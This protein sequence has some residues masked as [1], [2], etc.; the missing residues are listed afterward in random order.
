MK[1]TLLALA[2]VAAG[3]ANAGINLYDANGVKVDLSGA[4]EVQYR[5]DYNPFKDAELRIDDADLAINT[6]IAISEQLSA[7]AGTAF[8]YEGGDVRN[9]ELWAGFSS[10]FGTLTFG[11]QYMISDDSGI[12]KDYELGSESIDFVQTNGNEVIKY[13]YDNGTFYFGASHDLD[14]SGKVVSD[15]GEVYQDNDTRITDARIGYRVAGLDARVY[16][17]KGDAVAADL[18]SKKGAVDLEGYNVE[19]EYGFGALGLA[20]SFGQVEYKDVNSSSKVR[21]NIYQIAADYTI[22]KTTFAIGYNNY[23][24]RDEAGDNYAVYA[25]VTQQLH[26]NVKVYAEIGDTN[27]K[28]TE[29]KAPNTVTR[30]ADFG[31]VAGMEVKF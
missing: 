7:V 3:S 10:D 18:F 4:A 22:D 11:R 24:R 14:D 9:D 19:A 2:V 17:Y 26:S 23:D 25:N 21:G 27:V 31:Y 13:V 28:F 16:Y 30:S 8:E 29:G 20:A 12:G 6:S 5:E 15:E 1:K